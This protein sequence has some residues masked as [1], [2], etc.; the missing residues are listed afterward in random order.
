MKAIFEKKSCFNLISKKVEGFMGFPPM[1]HSHCELVY[2]ID[3]EINM[4]IDGIEHT[5]KKGEISVVFPYVTHSYENAP[6]AEAIIF[7]FD[8][9]SA[10]MFESTLLSHKPLFPFSDRLSEFYLL[11][12]RITKLCDDKDLIKRKTANAYFS[13]IIGEIIDVMALSEATSESPDISQQILSYCSEHF[14]DEDICI[15]KIA[16]A[17]YISPSYI[18]KIFA[19]KL[20]YKFRE[21][22]NILRISHAQKL[23]EKGE[24]KIVDIMLECGFKNQSSFNRIFLDT[25]GISPSEYKKSR[26][27][28]QK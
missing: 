18:S 23:I 2:L 5:L 7:L 1:F 3:G 4:V 26:F 16:D 19:N 15:K 12:E 27:E 14:A 20:N 25:C 21:Y 22:I 13:A 11:F 24:M 6:N 10:E 28:M 17:L 9:S 8:P